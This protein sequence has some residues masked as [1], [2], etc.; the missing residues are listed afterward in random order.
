MASTLHVRG[1]TLDKGDA[2][3]LADL[4]ERDGNMRWHIRAYEIGL[5]DGAPAFRAPLKHEEE[6]KIGDIVVLLGDI[7]PGTTA[8]KLYTG[9]DSLGSGPFV[10]LPSSDLPPAASSGLKS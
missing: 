1:I 8:S 6:I 3:R 7:A 5:E 4:P 9:T 10:S 2:T